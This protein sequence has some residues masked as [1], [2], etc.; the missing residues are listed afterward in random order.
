[1]KTAFIFNLPGTTYIVPINSIPVHD[2]LYDNELSYHNGGNV[3]SVVVYI[4]RLNGPYISV[5]S[6]TYRFMSGPPK[7]GAKWF[8][9]PS[10]EGLKMQQSIIES[11]IRFS[12]APAVYRLPGTPVVPISSIAYVLSG[13]H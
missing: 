11:N 1:M 12:I 10:V 5:Q 6:G 4:W 9:Q 13:I 3:R 8:E 7:P 2:I